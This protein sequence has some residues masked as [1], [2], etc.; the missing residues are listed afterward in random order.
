M[1]K[2]ITDLSSEESEERSSLVA[3]GMR[4]DKQIRDFAYDKEILEARC[5]LWYHNL[6]KKYNLK[7]IN[8]KIDKN[9]I[10]EVEVP[11]EF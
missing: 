5:K 6:R 1:D 4:I 10:F 3:E 7:N 11:H 9:Q 8:I 2:F